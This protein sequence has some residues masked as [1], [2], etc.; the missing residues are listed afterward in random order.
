MIHPLI[1]DQLP[2]RMPLGILPD[3]T[4]HGHMPFERLVEL[5]PH[6]DTLEISHRDWALVRHVLPRG[7]RDA[8]RIAV[9]PI[10]PRIAA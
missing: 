7:L 2:I 4:K 10:V 3:S 8:S 1:H 5:H 6:A 9:A